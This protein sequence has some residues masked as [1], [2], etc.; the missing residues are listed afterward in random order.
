VYKLT[1]ISTWVVHARNAKTCCDM[2]LFWW[3]D[4][5]NIQLDKTYIDIWLINQ[6]MALRIMSNNREPVVY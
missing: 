4:L 3:W 1:V 2:H 6:L 5:S